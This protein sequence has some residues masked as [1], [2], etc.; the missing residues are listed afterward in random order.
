[1]TAESVAIDTEGVENAVLWRIRHDGGRCLHRGHR[2]PPY[3]EAKAVN[4][5]SG[6]KADPSAKHNPAE[7]ASLHVA[8][9]RSRGAIPPSTSQCRS[10]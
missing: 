8:S 6:A 9:H 10:C 2:L 7:L 1:M 4:R 3:W 5:A